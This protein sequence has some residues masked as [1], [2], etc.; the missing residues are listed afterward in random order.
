MLES[1]IRHLEQQHEALDKQIDVMEKTGRFD[2]MD[3]QYLKKKRLQIRDE[4]IELRRK[5]QS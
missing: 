3:L 1:R 5:Q 2:D 4:L